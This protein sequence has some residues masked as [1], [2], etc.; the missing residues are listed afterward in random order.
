MSERERELEIVNEI[1]K[2]YGHVIDLE[3]QPFV[4]VEILRNFG[5]EFDNG[6]GGGP[7]GTPPSTIAGTGPGEEIELVDVMRVVLNVQ[8]EVLGIKA[9]LER[10]AR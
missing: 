5:R 7:P 9:Q 3:K 8:R 6:Q 2:R 10:G 1:A 4:M